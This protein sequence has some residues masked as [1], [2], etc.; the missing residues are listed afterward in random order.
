MKSETISIPRAGREIFTRR[1]SPDGAP[2]GGVLIAHGLV[3][4][5]LRYSRL[6]DALTKAG[7]VVSAL[8]H[9]GHGPKC[10]IPD[11]GFFADK[12][13][14]R[15]CLEDI[16]AVARRARADFPGLPLVFFGHS[17]GSY[18]GQTYIAEHGS[19]LAAAVLSATCG[20]PPAILP[21]GRRVAQF[22]RW[23]LGPRAK[24]AL[25]QY[26]L[27]GALNKP[28]LPA[29]TPF[30]WLSRDPVEVDRYITDIFCGF[31]ITNQLALDLIGGLAGLASPE[32][33]ARI[34]KTLPIYVAS[35]ERDPL[36][37]KLQGLV[38]VYE[39]AGLNLTA[40]IYPGAR[41]ELFNE[42]NRDEVTADLLT[43]L[44]ANAL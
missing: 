33:A 37:G 27:F 3:E 26:L 41:H 35:G 5:S 16:D 28:F 25:V 7:Y 1:W 22:E 9:R 11:L 34:P 29:R 15:A 43:W 4:H 23:R 24:S 30:D 8:D 19:E 6:A 10:P 39:A 31:P 14:W 17:T 18:L 32:M 12:D 42:T 13:G 20:P 38:D 44:E 40:R 36:A 21:I 2:R